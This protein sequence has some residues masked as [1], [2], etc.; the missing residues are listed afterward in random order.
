MSV[1]D[2]DIHELVRELD[3][4][5]QNNSGEYFVGEMLNELGY[6]HDGYISNGHPSRDILTG[7]SIVTLL[8]HHEDYD[9]R[10]IDAEY[11]EL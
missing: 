1:T 9:I 8:C 3:E 11:W 5:I 4:F 10:R 6:N 7:E 2:Q